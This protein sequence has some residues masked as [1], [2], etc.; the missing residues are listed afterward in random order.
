MSSVN[1]SSHSGSVY[2]RLYSSLFLWVFLATV[3]VAL[4]QTSNASPPTRFKGAAGQGELFVP[5]QS[6]YFPASTEDMNRAVRAPGMKWMR[7]GKRAPNA[8]K[9]MRFGKRAPN[10]GK[11]MRFGKRTPQD[12]N[13]YGWPSTT[14]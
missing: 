6:Y 2:L 3:L 7:F 8:G 10:G 9:W 4:M 11:W 1:S 5:S 13:S 12:T 14:R